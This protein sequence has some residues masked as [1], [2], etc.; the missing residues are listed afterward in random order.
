MLSIED[1]KLDFWFMDEF[2][3][4]GFL[5]AGVGAGAMTGAGGTTIP[6]KSPLME[7]LAGGCA[8]NENPDDDAGAGVGEDTG[9]EE[10]E[11]KLN[12]EVGGGA[13]VGEKF[14]KAAK[15]PF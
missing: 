12:P 6:A 7:A 11:M 15:S 1:I 9:T 14:W 2:D 8:I 5:A 13:G 3:M 4:T 10:G